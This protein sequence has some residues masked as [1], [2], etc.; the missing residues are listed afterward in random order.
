MRLVLFDIDG[1]LIRAGTTV[2][3]AAFAHAFRTVYGLD[4]TLDGL[5]AAGRTDTWL[6]HEPLRQAGLKDE[7]IRELMPM[8]F[9]EMGVYVDLRLGSLGDNVLPGVPRLLQSLEA[10]GVMLGL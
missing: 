3:K 2:H 4:L 1:T 6:L 7:R 10:Q 9:A 5:S 8:A